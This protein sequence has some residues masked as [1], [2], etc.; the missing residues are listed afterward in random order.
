MQL[1]LQ[2]I[3]VVQNVATFHTATVIKAL[4]IWIEVENLS[5]STQLPVVSDDI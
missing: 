4:S 2:N 1:F 5:I 3:G